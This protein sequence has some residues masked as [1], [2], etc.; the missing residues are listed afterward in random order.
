VYSVFAYSL[1]LEAYGLKLVA[2]FI[3][4]WLSSMPRC[5]CYRLPVSGCRAENAESIINCRH[6][7]HAHL[8]TGIWY[9]V[10]AVNNRLLKLKRK[11][12]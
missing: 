10:T 9:P 7:E 1:R 12:F 3:C 2:V 6:A 8:V 5:C 11:I 4:I